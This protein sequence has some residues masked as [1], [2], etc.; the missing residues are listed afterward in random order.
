VDTGADAETRAPSKGWPRAAGLLGIVFAT[1]VLR[2]GVLVAVPLVLL[3]VKSGLRSF[4]VALGAAAGAAIIASGSRDGIW[5]AER[6]W[7]L[8]VGGGFLA[9]T[10][11][12]PA[13]AFS[14]RALGAVMAAVVVAAVVLASRADAWVAIDTALSESARAGIDT[15][16][17]A[18][19]ALGDGGEPSP[20]LASTLQRVADAQAAVAP[21]FVCLGSMAAL[22]VAWWARTRLV[23]EGDQGLAPLG[24]FR[25][26]DHLVW[27]FVA[28]LMLVVL[29]W[30][31]A[32]VRLG[33]NAV[34]FMGALYALRGAAVF[35]FVSGGLSLFGYVAFV[36]GM[37]LAAPVLVGMAMLVG[38]GDTWL[39]IRSRVRAG[40]A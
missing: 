36:V 6:A 14:S 38:I 3:L 29:Q 19:T 23:G 27:L 16:L 31:D 39:D 22:G 28:G 4:R 1:S 2:P 35:M 13:W 15:T 7:A 34:V 9:L 40:A 33:S 25:F 10:M 21:A 17:L 18:L 32:L 11:L 5:Y 37:V 30:G 8:L 24:S 12:A 20:E 26:N